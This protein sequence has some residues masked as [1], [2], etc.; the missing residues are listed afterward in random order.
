VH[1]FPECCGFFLKSILQSS[2]SG[3]TRADAPKSSLTGIRPVLTPT[4]PGQCVVRTG[5]GRAAATGFVA[6][7]KSDAQMP[8]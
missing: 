6:L 1:L 5:A 8:D 7:L 4:L 3:A 2:T